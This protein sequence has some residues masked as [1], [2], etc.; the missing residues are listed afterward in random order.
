[1]LCRLTVS[2]A[3]LPIGEGLPAAPHSWM[4]LEAVLHGQAGL[5]YGL[6]GQVEPQAM[7]CD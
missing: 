4:G 6:T 7:L 3:G 2:L 5:P 1:M